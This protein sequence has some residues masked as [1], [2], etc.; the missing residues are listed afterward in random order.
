M[1]QRE[2]LF[3]ARARILLVALAIVTACAAAPVFSAPVQEADYSAVVEAFFSRNVQA[4]DQAGQALLKAGAKA[5]PAVVAGIKGEAR[6]RRASML[7]ARMGPA[8]AKALLALVG[9]PKSGREAASLLFQTIGT[10]SAVLAPKLLGCM[11]GQEQAK[12]N[13]GMSLVKAMSPQSAGQVPLLRKALKDRDPD[14][15]AYA[16]LA[17]GQIRGQA[18]AAVPDL[19]AA[20]KDPEP[21]V[22]YDAVLA[23]GRLGRA[24]RPAMAALEALSRQSAPEVKAAV[25]EALRSING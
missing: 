21:T 13:C 22:R 2:P 19:A 24:A 16:A 7:L 20:L 23:L 12:Q 11:R 15:R 18:K 5:V 4:R 9:D 25:A 14:V 10:D 6:H 3:C 8:G 17:L 1:A